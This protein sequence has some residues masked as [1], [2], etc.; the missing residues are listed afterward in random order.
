MNILE[1]EFPLKIEAKTTRYNG[2]TNIIYSVAELQHNI[3]I[4]KKE[5][6][7]E[8]I[9]ACENLSRYT[10]NKT[11]SLALEREISELKI[12]LDILH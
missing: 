11:D 4:N 2:K 8:Q 9:K 10:T 7:R 6:I 3:C 12:A 5:I 1:I